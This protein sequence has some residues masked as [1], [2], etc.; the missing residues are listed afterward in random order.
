MVLEH[1]TKLADLAGPA[2]TALSQAFFDL[3]LIDR[4][5]RRFALHLPIDMWPSLLCRLFATFLEKSLKMET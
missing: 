1:K 2:T 4:A 3:S 5:A